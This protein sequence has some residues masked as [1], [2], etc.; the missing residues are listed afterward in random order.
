MNAI[1]NFFNNIPPPQTY[2]TKH[3]IF[4]LLDNQTAIETVVESA[5]NLGFKVEIEADLVETPI[6][7]GCRELVS[8]LLS[9]WKSA[10]KNPVALI[11]G[12]E[13]ACPVR[14]SGVGGRNSEATLR[15]L[16]EIEK[17]KTEK[18]D[19]A[20][21]N[22]GTDGIDGNSSATGA[23]ADSTTLG[24]AKLMNLDAAEFLQNSDAFTFFA[25]LDD[26]ITTG[27]TGTN[28]RDIRILLAR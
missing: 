15:C 22:C 18:F 20:I 5:N 25:S 26:A 21:L 1:D 6:D 16:L 24:R 19:F 3:S 14:G 23:I 2:Q 13:F 4:T 7:K 28:V 10:N 9:L 27:A 11:S 17:L 8:R 12:G